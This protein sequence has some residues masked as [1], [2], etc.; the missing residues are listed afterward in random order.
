MITVVL[1]EKNYCDLKEG[2]E[3]TACFS[4]PVLDAHKELFVKRSYFDTE[5]AAVRVGVDVYLKSTHTTTY[6][7]TPKAL[8]NPSPFW[9]RDGIE[10]GGAR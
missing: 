9:V 3:I 8:L 2:K 7:L 10:Q 5:S 4:Q 1:T 6:I